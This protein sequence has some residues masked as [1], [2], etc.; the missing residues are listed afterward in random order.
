[1]RY[2]TREIVPLVW[3]LSRRDNRLA[4]DFGRNTTTLSELVFRLDRF[5][6]NF[7]KLSLE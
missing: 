7:A 1:M 4:F 6:S 3:G 2:F 5:S